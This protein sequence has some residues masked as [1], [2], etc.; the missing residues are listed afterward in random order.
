MT[1]AQLENLINEE[2]QKVKKEF[3]LK[4]Q[5]NEIE[6]ELAL[7]REVHAGP[8]M[9]PGQE[10]VHAGQKTPVF[11]KKGSAIVED[12]AENMDAIAPEGGEDMG[13]DADVVIEKDKLLAA[14][15]ELGKE[16]NLTGMIDFDAVEEMPGEEG[17]IEID[18]ADLGG[19]ESPESVGPENTDVEVVT[20][21]DDAVSNEEN[22]DEEEEE[23][24]LDECG[25]EAIQNNDTPLEKEAI[26]E[27][28]ED[29]RKKERLAEEVNRWKFLAG[30]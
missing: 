8:D 9:E 12:E 2:A 16:L 10:G 21:A 19:E 6:K 26:M 25:G 14:I 11:E 1:K 13:G 4:K 7:L 27:S 20:G 5:L 23:A 22:P 28:A 30:M 29:T 15:K 3:L 18:S 17:E 24:G